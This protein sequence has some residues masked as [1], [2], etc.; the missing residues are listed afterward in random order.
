MT[1]ARDLEFRA[2]AAAGAGDM[3]GARLLLEQAVAHEGSTAQTW[4]KL[5]A[6][7]K[8]A[9]DVAGSLDAVDRALALAPLDFTNLLSRAF[10]LE[11][12]DD[13]QSA[14][15]FGH[16]LAQLPDG[17]DL[18]PPMQQPVAHARKRWG[19]LQAETERHLEAAIP[20]SIAGA[21]RERA[22]RFV[23]NRSR[24]TSHYHQEPSDF[25]YSGLPEREVHDR[26]DFPEL[27]AFEAATNAIRAEFEAL[28]A[29]NE[30]QMVPYIQYPERVPLRQWKELNRNRDWTAIHLIQNGQRIDANALHCPITMAAIERLPQPK[31]R[32]ASPNAMFSLLAPKTRIPPHSG[33][34]NVRLVCHLPLIVPPDCGFRVG[35]TE[36]EWRVGEAFVFDDTIEHMAWNDSD[37][38]RVVLI[39][40]LWAPSLSPSE[41]SAITAI[42][43]ASDVGFGSG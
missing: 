37:Q 42:I 20:E 38:L 32:G 13:P 30:A 6:M 16:A 14:L 10:L 8:A 41:R 35:A 7:R 23:S 21:E 15:A 24:R 12:L 36:R 4:S 27:A 28:V 3:H 17:Q 22:L 2:D 19:K 43:E 29:A 26:S 40:D 33:V 39:V 9:G 31:I 11:A 25:H 18:P 34:A 1:D 5:S